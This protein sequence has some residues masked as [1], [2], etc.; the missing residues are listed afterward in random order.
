M[1]KYKTLDETLTYIG[2]KLHFCGTAYVSV[3]DDAVFYPPRPLL[4]VFLEYV[5]GSKPMPLQ[6]KLDQIIIGDISVVSSG[7]I[8]LSTNRILFFCDNICN[9]IRI[10]NSD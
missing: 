9:F 5:L 4:G 8:T 3:S 6:V 1:F 10:H 7:Y 2:I